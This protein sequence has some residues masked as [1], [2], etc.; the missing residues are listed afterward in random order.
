[1]PDALLAGQGY[2][3][4]LTLPRL[5]DRWAVVRTLQPSD[6]TQFHDPLKDLVGKPFGE[7]AV[8]TVAGWWSDLAAD[9][10]AGAVGPTRLDARL[11]ELGWWV[12]H[13][14]DDYAL[15]E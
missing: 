7:Q 15:V 5:P 11:A 12:L 6:A 1:M 9:P 10:L 14:D 2:G 3:D 4:E 13:D 8:Y